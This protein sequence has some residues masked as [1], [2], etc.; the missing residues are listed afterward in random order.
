M[1]GDHL[2]RVLEVVL[3]PG[4]CDIPASELWGETRGG[5]CECV[6]LCARARVCTSIHMR[7]GTQVW[8]CMCINGVHA[9]MWV[10]C[11]HGSVYTAM[12]SVCVGVGGMCGQFV[13]TCVCVYTGVDG[14]RRDMCKRCVHA[15]GCVVC[16][17]VWTVCVHGC[18]WRM[19]VSV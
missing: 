3:S 7:A 11:I 1:S 16:M 5:V 4:S 6:C 14:V 2:Q 19:C 8:P 12:G 18:A 17:Q 15:L 13:Y 10:V 9:W